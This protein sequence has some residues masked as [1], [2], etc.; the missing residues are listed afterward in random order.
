M[1]CKALATIA[2]ATIVVTVFA[3]LPGDVSESSLRAALVSQGTR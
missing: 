1:L 2:V 3:V